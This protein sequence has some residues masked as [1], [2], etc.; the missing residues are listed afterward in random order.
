MHLRLRR[1]KIGITGI[2]L[3][4]DPASGCKIIP[5]GIISK[6]NLFA[7]SNQLPALA[8]APLQARRPH[9]AKINE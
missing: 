8:G 2:S 3:P 5:N 4:Y 9:F 1:A 7:R 6:I